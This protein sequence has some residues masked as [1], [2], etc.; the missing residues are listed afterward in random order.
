MRSLPHF[1]TIQ[2]SVATIFVVTLVA[3][4]YF[5]MARLNLLF[6]AITFPFTLGPIAAYHVN[7]TKYSLVVGTL[8]SS[9]CSLIGIGPLILAMWFFVVPIGWIDDGLLTRSLF[10]SATLSYFLAVSLVGG[11]VGG[12]VAGQ[13]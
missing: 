10:V 11:Y 2:F 8:Y 12:I 6:V 3:A 13:D 7:K 5:A 4:L 9:L 1:Q